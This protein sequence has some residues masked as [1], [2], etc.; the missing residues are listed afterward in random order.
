[1]PTAPGNN[2]FPKLSFPSPGDPIRADDFKRLS[3]SLRIIYDVFA[4]SSALQG[5]EFG[6]AKLALTSQQYEIKRVMSVFG[7]EIEDSND[8]SLDNRKVI[9]VMP[10]ELGD[11]SVAVILTEA[12]ETRRFAPNLMGLTYSEAS[13]RLRSVLGDVTFPSKPMNAPELTGLT[14][15]QASKELKSR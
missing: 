13:E 3:Q 11:R 5:Q 4:L 15:A 8:S 9:Q 1:L 2:P 7:T 14:V 12:V 10:L 6:V